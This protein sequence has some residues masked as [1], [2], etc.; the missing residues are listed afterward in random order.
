MGWTDRLKSAADEANMT[1]ADVA[2]A[3]GLPEDRVRKYVSAGTANPR[4]SAIQDIARVLG[5]EYLWLRDGI[6]PK[7]AGDGRPEHAQEARSNMD[8]QAE[9]GDRMRISREER[10]LSVARA[11]AGLT[12]GES[13]WRSIETGQAAPTLV[14][15]Q[16]ISERLRAS[17]DWLVSG[18]V[19]EPRPMFEPRHE[20]TPT[21]HERAQ[22]FTPRYPPSVKK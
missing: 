21:L 5:V 10:G 14:E 1:L 15:L 6:E 3:A 22:G 11:C 12:I 13:R 8:A 2:R 17:L 20:A 18:W 16:V 7:Y 9:F 4:G 19:G